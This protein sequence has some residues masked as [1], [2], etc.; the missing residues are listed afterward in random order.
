M[1]T[2]CVFQAHLRE[3]DKIMAW[4]RGQ[5][6]KTDLNKT[7]GRKMEIA[8][9]EAVVNVIHYAYGSP[10]GLLEISSKIDEKKNHLIFQLRDQGV[11]FNPV[12]KKKEPD[13]ES[14]AAERDVGGLGIYFMCE[15]TDEIHYERQGESNVLTLVK[16]ISA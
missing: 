14:S 11:A 1:Q 12:E 16:A 4:I 10:P 6:Q 2:S 15:M 7:E 8:I 3:L 9:E 5:I 13:M